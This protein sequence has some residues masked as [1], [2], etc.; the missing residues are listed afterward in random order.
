MVDILFKVYMLFCNDIKI[1]AKTKVN[2]CFRLMIRIIA[3]TVVPLWYKL[4]SCSGKYTIPPTSKTDGRI[5]VSLTSFP[6]RINKLW[7]VIESIM[8]QKVK[9]DM[10]ILWLSKEQFSSIETLPVELRKLQKRGLQICLREGDIRS[11]KKYYYVLCEYP[12]DNLFT[13]DDDIIYPS[14]TLSSVLNVARSFPKCVVGRYS[15]HIKLDSEGN[16]CFDRNY[17]EKFVLQPSWTTFIGSGGGAL[18]PIGALPDLAKDKDAFMSICKT[19]DDVWLNT[20]CRYSGYKFVGIMEKCPLL[21]VMNRK[22]VTLAS[23]NYG[24]ENYKQQKA[25]RNYCIANGRDPFR[26]LM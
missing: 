5:I 18:F 9:P 22:N 1:L 19:A 21:E 10:L 4:T 15:N 26:C 6:A 12:N 2:S 17:K 23:I 8:R 20:M 25:V 14:D 3:N 13:I 11:H 24:V 16:V 7:I